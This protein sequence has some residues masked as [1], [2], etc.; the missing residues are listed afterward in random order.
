MTAG[1]CA[2]VGSLFANSVWY[3]L[4]SVGLLVTLL[5]VA[6]FERASRYAADVFARKVCGEKATVSAMLAIC[7]LS[8]WDSHQLMRDSRTRARERIGD[9]PPDLRNRLAKDVAAHY[10][11]AP[12]LLGTIETAARA[13][14]TVPCAGERINRLARVIRGRGWARAFARTMRKAFALVLGGA[15]VPINLWEL[16][17]TGFYA[18]AGAAG[19]ILSV[20]VSTLFHLRGAEHYGGFIGPVAVFGVALGVVVAAR[21]CREGISAGKFGWAL[22]VMS[23]MFTCVAMLGFCL[24]G[25]GTLPRFSLQFPVCFLFVLSVSTLAGVMFVRLGPLF[26]IQ[27]RE[28]IFGD[29]SKTAQTLMMLLEDEKSTEPG[30]AATRSTKGNGTPQAPAR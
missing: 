27:T 8:G 13:F 4:L 30:P 20:A 6:A 16:A 17:G 19:A 28:P 15:E 5:L 22:T 11:G 10:E 1:L 21:V 9:M 26:G 7:G 2:L 18:A 14:S 29:P 3:G 23:T 12:C 24:V 25:A